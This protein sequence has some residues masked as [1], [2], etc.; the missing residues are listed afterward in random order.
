[1]DSVIETTMSMTRKSYER[2]LNHQSLFCFSATTDTLV[3]LLDQVPRG[4]ESEH[5]QGWDFPK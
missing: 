3:W 4:V 2:A 5:P 1:M